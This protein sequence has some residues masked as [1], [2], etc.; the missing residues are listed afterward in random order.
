MGEYHKQTHS[1]SFGHP[2]QPAQQPAYAYLSTPTPGRPNRG[3][4]FSCKTRKPEFS[5][6]PGFININ[7]M[8][9]GV[10]VFINAKD[11]ETSTSRYSLS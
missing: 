10:H 6:E 5:L 1:H 11:D 8:A 9:G 4:Y 3:Q 2:P 7:P